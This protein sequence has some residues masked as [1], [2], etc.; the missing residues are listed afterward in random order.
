MTNTRIAS[1]S[2]AFLLFGHDAIMNENGIE[3]ITLDRITVIK[4]E[5]ILIELDSLNINSS[6]LFPY[7]ENSAKYTA[8][9]YK[10]RQSE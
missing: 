1:Q 5:K 3:G 8:D 7:I 9:R 10:F 6:T 4:K 2:G